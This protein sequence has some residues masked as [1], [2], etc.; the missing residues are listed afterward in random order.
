MGTGFAFGRRRRVGILATLMLACFGASGALAQ[1][2]APDIVHLQGDWGRAQFSVE[3]ADDPQEQSRG[4]MHREAMPLSA[5]MYFVYASPRRTSF[6]MRNTLI[7]LDMLFVDASG[8]VT[9]IHH[10]AQPLDET[11]IPSEGE[12]LAVLEING[13]LAARL[14]ITKGTQVR[15]PAHADWSPAWPC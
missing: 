11:P 12:V 3:L 8:V 9:H 7:P 10:E 14:G 1:E 6:W 13:G 5:G 4:L 2:C 15:H